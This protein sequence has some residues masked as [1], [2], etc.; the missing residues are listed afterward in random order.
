ME[1]AAGATLNRQTLFV[2]SLNA[3]TAF[4]YFKGEC[5]NISA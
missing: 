2:E 4:I 3:E 1:F 5:P